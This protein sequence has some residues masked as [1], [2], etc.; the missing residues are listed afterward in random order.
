MVRT[1]GLAR[2]HLQPLALH[3]PQQQLVALQLRHP[4]LRMQAQLTIAPQILKL[5]KFF[6]SFFILL[7]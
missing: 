3:L 1:Q 2:A 4:C 7:Q 5:T 6:F